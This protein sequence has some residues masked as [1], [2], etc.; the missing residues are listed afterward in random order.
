MLKNSYGGRRIDTMAAWNNIFCGFSTTDWC[1]PLPFPPFDSYFPRR[2]L[3]RAEKRGHSG[4]V[5]YENPFENTPNW[6]YIK[7][8]LIKQSN[9]KQPITQQRQTTTR[10]N[11]IKE[12][13]V[14]MRT[15]TGGYVS[16]ACGAGAKGAPGGRS[17]CT[18]GSGEIGLI[19]LMANIHGG[20]GASEK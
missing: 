5:D 3:K 13:S 11:L 12:I 15:T 1:P 8:F 18:G 10:T 2:I 4:H 17:T 7:H 16:E 19:M 6:S 20:G 9:S 14:E